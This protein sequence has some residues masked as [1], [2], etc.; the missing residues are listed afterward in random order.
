MATK[1]RKREIVSEL[2]TLFD[3]GKVAIVADVSGLTVKEL[4]TLRRSLDKN[5]AKLRVAKNTLAKIA[6]NSKDFDAIKSLTKGPSAIVVGYDDPAAPA[7]TTVNFFKA[8]KKGSIR[9]GV[10][11]GK[12]ITESEVKGLAELPSKEQLLSEIIAGL[13]SGAR[14][15]AGILNR[16]ICDIALL[17]EEVAKKNGDAG[18]ESAKPA[19]EA[20]KPAEAAAET[21]PAEAAAEA[22]PAEAAAEEKPAGAAAEAKPAEAAAEEKPAE[23]AAEEKPAEAAAEEKPAEATAETT[24]AK[25]AE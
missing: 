2:Q 22:K 17:V 21:K 10:I 7:K 16:V 1:E 14:N 13:D 24:E 5:Q 12:T 8:L 19:E 3:N 9:G 11:E 25:P 23:A 18:S 6:T 20:A 4:T 15:I